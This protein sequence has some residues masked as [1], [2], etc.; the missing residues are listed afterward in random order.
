MDWLASVLQGQADEPPT[1]EAARRLATGVRTWLQSGGALSLTR[2]L[3]LHHSPERVRMQMRD[4]YL[5]QAGQ[6]LGIELQAAIL[7]A[8]M[9]E[10]MGRR[11][12]CWLDLRE[13][14]AYA[15]PVD[16][17]LWHAA[18]AAGGTLRMTRRRLAQ[19]LAGSTPA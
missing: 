6:A 16:A 13:P 15:D 3:G 17:C 11:W 18:R 12:P 1:P 7:H 8:R 4:H 14:P 2:C 10:F 19:I 5:R 9:R